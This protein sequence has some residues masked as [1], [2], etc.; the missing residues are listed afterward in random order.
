MDDAEI[1][2]RCLIYREVLLRKKITPDVILLFGSHAKKNAGKNSD[3]DLAVVSRNLGKNRLKEG[4]LLNLLVWD[5]FPEAEV[6]P[7]GLN[8]YL[9]TE[10]ISPILREIKRYGRAIL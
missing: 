7:I 8:E 9:S 1:K 5:V 6:I 2:R 4:A 10:S 3:V